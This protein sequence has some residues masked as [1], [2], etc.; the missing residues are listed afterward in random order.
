MYTYIV[1][2]I[3]NDSRAMQE[4]GRLLNIDQQLCFAHGM[5]LGVIEVWSKQLSNMM[6]KKFELTKVTDAQG[7]IFMIVLSFIDNSP[8]KITEASIGPLINNIRKIILMFKKSPTKND[9]LQ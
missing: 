4:V 3:E 1:A 9:N 7:K 8:S 5:Q 2:I 6:R